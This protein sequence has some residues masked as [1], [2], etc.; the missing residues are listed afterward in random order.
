MNRKVLLYL[1]TFMVGR[2][3]QKMI[4]RERTFSKIE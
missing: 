4:V 1:A 3:G 2:R